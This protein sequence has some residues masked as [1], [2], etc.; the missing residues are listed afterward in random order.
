MRYRRILM[1]LSGGAI[2]GDAAWGFDPAALNHIADEVLH[3]HQ[4]G[5][6]VGVMVGGGNI[7]KGELG[8]TWGIER[9]EA[10]NIGMMA[11]VINSLLLR[12][13]LQARGQAEVRVMTALPINTVAEPFLR[14]RAIRHL[15]HHA[16]VVLA[17]GT[18]NPYVTTD[19][20]AVQ[21]ALEL[22]ADA[23]LSAKNGIDG[24]YTADPHHDPQARR[25]QTIS[26]DTV[27]RDNL[28]ALDQSAVLLA[29]D[30]R[31]PIHVFDFDASRAMLDICGGEQ[32]GTQI[33]WED[34]LE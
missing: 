17:A 10:D 3:L 23:L 27:I 22:R 13:V 11:T 12:G 32:V 1:K 25:Y 30:H 24:I 31:L 34:A 16:I 4:A 26:Y 33:G 2:A 7:F 20:P 14:L 28:Q 8:E 15:D 29:R 5:I 6:Q 18:G 21:R 9:A 19:Y